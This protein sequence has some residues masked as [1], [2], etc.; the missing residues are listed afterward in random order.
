MIDIL[1]LKPTVISKDLKGKY[2]L[3]Y[4]KPKVGKT[5]L[6]SHFPKNLLI[7]FERGYNAVGGIMAQDITKWA[8][9]KTVIKQLQKEEAKEKFSTITIDTVTEAWTMCEK[10]ICIQNNV[11]KI[12]DIPW[13]QGYGAC[14]EEFAK[15]LRDITMMGYGLVLI[16]HNGR[17]I[18]VDEKGS[19]IE[20]I[21]PELPK[22]CYDVVNKLVDIIAYISSEP[23]GRYLYTRATSNIMAGS[24]FPYLAEKIPL[25]YENLANAIAEAIEAQEKRDGVQV[26]EFE[27]RKEDEV[28]NFDEIRA[29]AQALWAKL[30]SDNPDEAAQEDNAKRIMDR[31]SSIFGHEMKLSEISEN[32][33]DLFNLVLME[34]KE[35]DK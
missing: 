12:S 16:A 33:V 35:L 3:I 15:C 27:E 31:I 8:E 34:M 20:F 14:K 28:L 11:Q 6:A 30:V 32:Q 24:R 25:G 9:F 17:R 1:N 4:G 29:E 21:S 18:E 2:I 10:Y 26:V 13:G 22:R 7:A 19:E 23:D 5:T